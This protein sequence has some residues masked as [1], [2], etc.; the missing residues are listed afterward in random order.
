LLDT[1]GLSGA[2][3]TATLATLCKEDYMDEGPTKGFS[4]KAAMLPDIVF[5]FKELGGEEDG[6]LGM[7]NVSCWR[8]RP[9]PS[10]VL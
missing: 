10:G 2:G 3:K 4:I 5:N 7:C 1:A 6:G 8:R 9:P